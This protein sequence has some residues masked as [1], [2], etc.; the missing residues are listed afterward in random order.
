MQSIK[1]LKDTKDLYLN[2]VKIHFVEVYDLTQGNDLNTIQRAILLKSQLKKL[3]AIVS[4]PYSVLIEYQMSVNDK[5]R[6]VSN[7]LVYH[8]CDKANT[9]L[10]GPSLKN[11]INLSADQSLSHGEFMSKYSSKYTA[12]KNHSKENF[13]HYISKIENDIKEVRLSTLQK[14]VHIGFGG[15]LDL[16]IRL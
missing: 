6:N 15:T 3:D 14:I 5:S 12:N 10:V 1:K 2:Y 4:P 13:K 8:Y 9:Y 16:K 7:Q 11:K